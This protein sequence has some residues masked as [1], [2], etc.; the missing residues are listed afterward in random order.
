MI[1]NLSEY[2]GGAL[3]R[4]TRGYGLA[5][6]P[7]IDRFPVIIGSNISMSYAAAAMRLSLNGFRSNFVDMLGELLDHEPHAFATLTKRILSV[8]GARLD[9]T[10]AATAPGT[11]EEKKAE[12]LRAFVERQVLA[13]P[14]RTQ[15]FATL[16]WALF[17]GINAGENHW[18][19]GVGYSLARVSFIHS[20]RLSYPNYGVWDLHVWDQGAVVFD[21]NYNR[22]SLT[23][24]PFGLR[25][26]DYPNKF[27]VHSP[28]LRA[29]YPTREGLG[30][31]LATYML[32][33]RLVMRVSAQDFERFVKPWVVAYLATAEEKDKHRP[34]TGEDIEAAQ[35]AVDALGV[36]SLAS[37]CLP[38]SVRLEVM[39]AASGLNQEHFLAY[40]DSSIS[41]ACVGQTFTT[42]SGKFGSRS[43]A[44]VGKGEALELARYDASCFCDTMHEG[45]FLP[46][47]TLNFPGCEELTPHARIHTDE[48]PDPLQIMNVAEKAVNIG[49][50]VDAD[51]LAD[52]VG[53]DLVP[54]ENDKETR[55][56]FPIMAQKDPACFDADLAERAAEIQEQYP[57]A[58]TEDNAGDANDDRG[59]AAKPKPNDS[60]A[61]AGADNDN[62]DPPPDAA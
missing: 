8:A 41:K 16:L 15:L 27:I 55:R 61:D 1:K 31:I 45:W 47:V 62:D 12:E 46:L 34:A 33:K 30:R 58:D 6:W 19:R 50:P 4:A 28:Q 25:I 14:K 3:P 56:L 7:A 40:L 20:R 22:E 32:I 5:P 36:G 54:K 38:D 21:R 43:Q 37:A 52:E 23:Q 26:A 29:D 24:G 49:M 35:D 17:Y 53:L 44:T 39:K 59:N 10:A 57:A 2:T 18:K 42:E 9:I 51:A 11:P 13:I 60:A 48:A